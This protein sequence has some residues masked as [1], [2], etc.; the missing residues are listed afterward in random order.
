MRER[1][2]I[3]G[4]MKPC[5]VRKGITGREGMREGGR[6]REDVSSTMWKSWR[7][8]RRSDRHVEGGT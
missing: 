1:I 7:S 8:D 6:Q 3:V 5:M 4:E 2:K